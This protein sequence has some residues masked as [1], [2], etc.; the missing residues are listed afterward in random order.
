MEN[1]PYDQEEHDKLVAWIDELYQQ[2]D[3]EVIRILSQGII[4]MRKREAIEE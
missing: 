2:S 1:K 3:I 4:D